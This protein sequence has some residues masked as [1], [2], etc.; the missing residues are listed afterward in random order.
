MAATLAE[1]VVLAAAKDALYPTVGGD[2][3]RYAVTETQF[4]VVQGTRPLGPWL[5]ELDDA[6]LEFFEALDEPG[7]EPVTLP[8]EAL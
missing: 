4:T 2:S 3:N 6:I 1:P 7:G 5:N 8:P